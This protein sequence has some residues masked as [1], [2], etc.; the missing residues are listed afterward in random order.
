MI[1]VGKE[2]RAEDMVRKRK[3]IRDIESKDLPPGLEGVDKKVP[4]KKKVSSK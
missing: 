2:Y 4:G 3:K 1:E